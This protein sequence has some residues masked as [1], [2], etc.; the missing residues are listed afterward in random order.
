[1]TRSE[2]GQTQRWS[3]WLHLCE[4]LEQIKQPASQGPSHPSDRPPVQMEK[5]IGTEV[6]LG[7]GDGD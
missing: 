5:K 4:V 6:T 1:M 7:G 3:P 2:S